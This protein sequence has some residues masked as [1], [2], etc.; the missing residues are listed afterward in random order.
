MLR[1]LGEAG[2]L[3]I[4]VAPLRGIQLDLALLIAFYFLPLNLFF[5]SSPSE[6]LTP[7]I[8]QGPPS[9]RWFI[10]RVS[11][12]RAEAGVEEIL[13]E[14]RDR[15][16]RWRDLDVALPCNRR[17]RLFLGRGRS[18]AQLQ[19]EIVGMRL[20]QLLARRRPATD[21]YHRRTDSV[22]LVDR[23]PLARLAA[24]AN[25]PPDVKWNQVEL[26]K[27]GLAKQDLLEELARTASAGA[28]EV[29][30]TS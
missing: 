22:T 3:E 4:V 26:D 29:S 1:L 16:G 25:T 5:G 8:S 13:H 28:G 7:P 23:Q 24:S 21:V 18:R 15:T 2:G 12:T 14:L 30:W 9:G 10:I 19:V 27:L 11:G 17:T 20:V 6:L